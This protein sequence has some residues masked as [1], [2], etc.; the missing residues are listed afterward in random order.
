METYALIQSYEIIGWIDN[1]PGRPIPKFP[2]DILVLPA[3][4]AKE[5]REA[6]QYIDGIVT[7]DPYY[8]PE[9]PVIVDPITQV[10]NKVSMRQARLALHNAGL[11][12]AADAFV[13]SLGGAAQ[14]EWEYAQE[15]RRDHALVAALQAE[16]QLTDEQIDQLFIAANAL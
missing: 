2:A 10:P 12:S 1:P 4:I 9:E 7:I 15:I 13:Q 14:I 16:L 8:T 5:D 3:D 11:L 6:A